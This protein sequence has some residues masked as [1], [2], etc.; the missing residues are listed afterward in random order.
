MEFVDLFELNNLLL[1][2]IEPRSLWLICSE[3]PKHMTGNVQGSDI[4]IV[5]T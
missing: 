2:P 3:I 4:K 5:D 1:N